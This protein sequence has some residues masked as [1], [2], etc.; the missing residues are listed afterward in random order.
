MAREERRKHEPCAI[1]ERVGE[2]REGRIGNL[3]AIKTMIAAI[4]EERE[5]IRREEVEPL[6]EALLR[7]LA[8]CDIHG[9]GCAS[10]HGKPCNC[11]RRD[12]DEALATVPK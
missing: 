7:V 3:R 9:I 12:A 11:S 5:R 6:R 8:E 1:C 4:A 10:S 2:E